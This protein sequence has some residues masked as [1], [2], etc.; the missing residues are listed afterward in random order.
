MKMKARARKRLITWLLIAFVSLGIHYYVM[1]LSQQIIQGHFS[2]SGLLHLIHTRLTEPGDAVRYLDI[3]K[4]GYV[5]EG[6]NAINLVFYPL[7]PLLIR[8][9]S[10]LTGNL[11]FS[12]V[13]ISQA[14]YA[15]ASILMYELL[16]I[17]HTEKEAWYGV[18]LLAL[19]PFS[20]FVMGI[21]TEGLFLLLTIGCL[22]LLRKQKYPAAGIVGFFA[23]LCRTQGMLLIF[24]AAYELIV[25]RLGKEKRKFHPS[26]LS[27]LLIPAGFGVYLL[28]N[29]ALHGNPFQFLQYEAGDPWFQTSQW[30]GRNISLQFL[31]AHEYEGLEWVIYYVQIILYFLALGILFFGIWKKERMSELLYGGAYLGFTYLSGWMISGGRYMLGCVPLFIILAGIKNEMVRK[32]LLLAMCLFHFAYSLFFYIGYSIM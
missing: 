27:V 15:G 17:D 29:A 32:V 14:S 25:C 8:L 28:I 1:I 30:I 20:V 24:P 4:N 13:L 10:I 6:E 31:L 19:H 12:G 16:K 7:Y 11:A 21:Y 26:D 18:L 23:A 22:Y 3:A 2:F 5:R 9:F